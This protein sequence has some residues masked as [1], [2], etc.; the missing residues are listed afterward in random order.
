[1]VTSSERIVPNRLVPISVQL[2]DPGFY[3]FC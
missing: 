3:H 1:V 2:A